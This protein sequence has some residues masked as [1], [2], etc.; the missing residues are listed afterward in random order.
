[1]VELHQGEEEDDDQGVGV[2]LLYQEGG[3]EGVLWTW[4]G[5]DQATWEACFAST[6]T[7]YCHLLLEYIKTYQ[8]LGNFDIKICDGQSQ[9]LSF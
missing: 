4:E 6:G 1:M 7:F 8:Q 3:R 2:L 5:D 9:N